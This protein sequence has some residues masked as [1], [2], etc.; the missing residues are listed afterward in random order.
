[1]IKRLLSALLS[2]SL[3]L[4][5]VTLAASTAPDKKAIVAHYSDMAYAI[6]SDA[7][8]AAETL[9]Q[10]VDALLS[11]PSAATLEAA[12]DAWLAARVPYQQS[13]V[14][15]FGNAIVDDWE[16]K[17]NNWPLD[18]G[19]IDYVAD[20][21]VYALGNIAAELNIIANPSI[22]LGGAHIDATRITPELL[23]ELNELGGNA[24]NV[25]SG[26]HAVEFL[27]WGQDLNSHKPGAGQRPYTDYVSGEGCTHGHCDR[28]A[29][30]L[31]AATQLLAS[32][33]HD[34]VAQWAPGK[35]NYRKELLALPA[36]RGIARIFYGMGS[37]SLGELGGE[38][39]KVAL[40]ANS[41]EDEHD[42]FSDNTHNSHYYDGL[43]I[44][45]VYL[46]E[47]Q[48]LDGSKLTGPSLHDAVAA[49]NAD[50]DT[51]MRGALDHT[52]AEL[53]KLKALAEGAQPQPFDVLIAPG[54]EQ[55]RKLLISILEALSQQTRLL[56]DA[57][58][59]LDINPN[60]I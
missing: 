5:T 6:Y 49:A 19:L 20:D 51:K 15:R 42:C 8:T 27:L 7:A 14:F 10:R 59:S 37:L 11:A 50:A 34:M 32:D 53:S 4:P 2:C 46:G 23:E 22:D 36:E 58:A 60:A 45:N 31:R 26:Y 44:R 55:G 41:T 48:R 39:I 40:E 30:F 13:E 35:D 25:T 57:A 9:Q 3:F 16:G 17:V 52:M 1:M 29:D 38:R 24:A 47:Y 33:L 21:Y 28:R 12:R 18:E 54:N 43:G 56:E